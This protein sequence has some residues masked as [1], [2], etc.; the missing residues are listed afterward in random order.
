MYAFLGH[1]VYVT[2]K[3]E[4]TEELWGLNTVS[5]SKWEEGTDENQVFGSHGKSGMGMPML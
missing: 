1:T 4:K 2:P 5:W 3:G